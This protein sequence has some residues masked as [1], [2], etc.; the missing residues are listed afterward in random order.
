LAVD[1]VRDH[2]DMVD[3][4]GRPPR[5]RLLIT[6]PEDATGAGS[7]VPVAEDP[8]SG[9]WAEA[10]TEPWFDALMLRHVADQSVLLTARGNEI[11]FHA[12]PDAPHTAVRRLPFEQGWST[13]ALSLLDVDGTAYVHK[14]YRRLDPDNHEAELLRRLGAE[15]SRYT[16]PYLGGYTYYDTASRTGYPLGL[17]YGFFPGHGLDEPLRDSLR[18]LWDAVA[19]RPEPEAAVRAH[20]RPLEELLPAGGEFLRGFHTRLDALL[21][22]AAPAAS[23]GP[24]FRVEALLDRSDIRLR[25]LAPLVRDDAELSG[26]V[27]EAALA[28]LERQLRALRARAGELD[29]PPFGAGACHGDLHLSHFLLG[30]PD[31][32]ATGPAGASERMRIIDLSTPCTDPRAAGFRVQSPWQ[33]LVSLQRAL[34][35]FSADEAAD[36]TATLLGVPSIE[37]VRAAAESAAGLALD[38]SLWTPPALRTLRT[39]Q[40]AAAAWRRRVHQLLLDG[41]FGGR[42]APSAHGA[43][44]LLRLDRLLWETAYNCAHRRTYY[45]YIDLAFALSAPHE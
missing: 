16:C 29:R 12:G 5:I 44:Q 25:E 43:W 15:D 24:R 19:G 9:K 37:V 40:R 42:P 10:R 17:V 39:V 14:T 34:E 4:A 18:G 23:P 20:V 36:H 26:P 1:E 3:T 35:Y 6:A 11:R 21:H 22:G 31:A 45:Q 7:F 2:V 32:P 28:S 41:Y 33:D 27:R 8:V 38:A 30:P 13:N